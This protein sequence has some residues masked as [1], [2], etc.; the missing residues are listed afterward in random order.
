MAALS[1]CVNVHKQSF[2]RTSSVP[3]QFFLN[4]LS[5]LQCIRGPGESINP[6]RLRAFSLNWR[7]GIGAHL[8]LAFAAVVALAI[9]A[10]L[11]IEHEISVVRTTRIVRVEASPVLPALVA[12]SVR[13]RPAAEP[14]VPQ[15]EAVSSKP[16]VTALEHFAAAV[17]NRLD[18]HNDDSDG[19]LA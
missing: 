2:C 1:M 8:G 12:A 4:P 13:A 19:A 17:R 5:K 11:L 7:W 16:L 3:S 18:I 9:A 15:I 14:T 6:V 10:N